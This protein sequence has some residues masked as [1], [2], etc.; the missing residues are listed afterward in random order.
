MREKGR[1]ENENPRSCDMLA[2]ST[3]Q[4]FLHTGD[5]E[6]LI[7]LEE[8]RVWLFLTIVWNAVSAD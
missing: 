7:A 2:V 4:E 6:L 5:R 3:D 1:M 8:G